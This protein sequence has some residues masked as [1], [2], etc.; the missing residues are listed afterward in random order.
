MMK[1]TVGSLQVK[2]LSAF[3]SYGSINGTG[4]IATLNDATV[5]TVSR[6]NVYT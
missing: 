6:Q 5:A 1:T 2:V 4:P 3:L